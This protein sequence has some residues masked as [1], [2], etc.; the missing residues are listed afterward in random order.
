MF[1]VFA[2]LHKYACITSK[3]YN[4]SFLY[5]VQHNDHYEPTQEEQEDLERALNAVNAQ[6]KSL[7]QEQLP[8]S[9]N[10]LGDFLDVDDEMMVATEICTDVLHSN[11]AADVRGLVHTWTNVLVNLIWVFIRYR[12]GKK[13]YEFKQ[14]LLK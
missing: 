7:E 9:S 1:C 6:L 5:A 14:K 13:N 11:D 2:I 4:Y 8:G 3:I 12:I 10:F